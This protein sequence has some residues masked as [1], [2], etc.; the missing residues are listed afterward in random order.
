M[1]GITAGNK[2]YGVEGALLAALLRGYEMTIMNRVK[3]AADNA[4]L[5]SKSTSMTPISKLGHRRSK[6]ASKA[7]VSSSLALRL[8]EVRCGS[9]E[10]R[11]SICVANC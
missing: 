7:R 2:P 6:A 4:Y 8:S 10:S 3:S 11:V 9:D 5:H 1:R